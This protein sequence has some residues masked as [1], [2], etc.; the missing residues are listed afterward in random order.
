MLAGLVDEGRVAALL[1]DLID[2]GVDDNGD[3]DGRGVD[4]FSDLKASLY[5]ISV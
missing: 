2:A 4:G 5:S 1:R 3:D